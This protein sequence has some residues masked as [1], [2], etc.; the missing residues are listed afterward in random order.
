MSSRKCSIKV[1]T[2]PAGG[3]YKY[4]DTS[5]F[6]RFRQYCHRS[7]GLVLN[8]LWSEHGIGEGWKVSHGKRREVHETFILP[9]T[10]QTQPK[11]LLPDLGKVCL[12]KIGCTHSSIHR[13]EDL[14][15]QKADKKSSS[16]C[17]SSSPQAFWLENVFIDIASSYIKDIIDPSDCKFNRDGKT[18]FS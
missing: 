16:A 8:S 15:Q 1:Q 4:F 2:D 10:V 9:P 14:Q 17:R 13:E 18:F 3:E 5:S 7:R 11:T 6:Q 12:Q